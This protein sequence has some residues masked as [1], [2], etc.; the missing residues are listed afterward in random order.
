MSYRA[1]GEKL[2]V[3]EETAYRDTAPVRNLTPDTPTTITGRD[4]KQY[5]ATHQNPL[6]STKINQD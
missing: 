4:G 1:I 3:T 6:K 5:T 2:G